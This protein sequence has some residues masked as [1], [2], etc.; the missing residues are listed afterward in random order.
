MMI[1]I[2]LLTKPKLLRILSITMVLED[3]GVHLSRPGNVFT[4][5]IIPM[6]LIRHIRVVSWVVN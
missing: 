3:L 5:M 4:V 2:F 6:V 1:V